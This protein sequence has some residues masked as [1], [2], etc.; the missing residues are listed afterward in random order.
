MPKYI[1]KVIPSEEEPNRRIGQ[2]RVWLEEA[3]KLANAKPGKLVVVNDELVGKAIF[4]S[5]NE[6][7]STIGEDPNEFEL[8]WSREKTD[9]D[10]KVLSNGKKQYRYFGWIQIMR[11]VSST[12]KKP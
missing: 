10:V 7:L 8:F 1:E 2:F 3:V 5:M 4:S 9:D 12:A 6:R 11:K